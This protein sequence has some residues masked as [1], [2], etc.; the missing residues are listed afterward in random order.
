MSTRSLT[1]SRSDWIAVL[2]SIVAVLFAIEFA[3]YLLTE[4][5]TIAIDPAFFQHTGWYVLE[6]GVPYVDVWDVNPPVPFAITAALAVLS[7]G[8]MYVL[9][10]LSVILTLLVAAANILLVGWVAFLVTGEDAAAVAAGLTMLV[11]PELFLLPLAGVWAQFYAL[12]F[13]VLSL[14]LALRDRPFL[15]GVAAALSAGSWQSGIAFAP[16][17]VGMTYQR[18]GGKDVLR[19][20]AG[21]GV[22]T[23]V[24]VLVFAAAGALVP[25]F[26]QTV[27]VPLVAGSPYTLA[28]R[29]FSILLV[30][31]YGS[32][33]LPVALYGWASTAV[34]DLR[35]RWWVPAGGVI[36]GLQVLVVDLDGSTDTFL[37]LAFVALG[38]AV[39]VERATAWRSVTTDRLSGDATRTNR[40]RWPVVVAVVAGLIVLSGLAWNVNSPPPK[41]TLE[42]MEREAEPDEHLPI[43]PDDA[44]SPS[45]RTIYWEQLKPETCHYRLSW[46]E[47]RWIAMTDDRLDAERCGGWPNRIDR[48]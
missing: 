29:G 46:T 3:A 25:M 8:N 34:R 1:E 12:F 15:A 9:H 36:L 11:V 14:A 31:G 33:L 19:A 45:M 6:G 44:D 48:G 35:T 13:G 28:E 24:V 27:I 5:P 37:W 38:V 40:Y 21:G 2:G 16:L 41:P 18:T 47:V 10:G 26:V 7:G 42:T 23:G 17:V 4:W 20:I 32:V 22:V 30:F 39:T 43:S